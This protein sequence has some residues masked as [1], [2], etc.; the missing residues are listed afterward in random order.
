[1]R[2]GRAADG[3]PVPLERGA[4]LTR[5]HVAEFDGEI[6]TRGRQGRTVR[7]K[8]DAEDRVTVTV[9]DLLQSAGAR[10]AQHAAGSGIS[11][12]C[13]S[14]PPVWRPPP[15]LSALFCAPRRTANGRPPPAPRSPPPC[16]RRRGKWPGT[17]PRRRGNLERCACTRPTPS[18]RAATRWPRMAR[19]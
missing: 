14:R 4:G 19:G 1:R 6:P 16:E 5:G 11:V 9:I 13:L 7:G 12:T 18:A 3:A 2:K 15:E 17:R 8:G 10:I